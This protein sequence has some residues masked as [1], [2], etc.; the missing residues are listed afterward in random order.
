[1]DIGKRL[2]QERKRLGLSQT[3]FAKN[4]GVSISSQ[5]RYESGDR[6]PDTSYLK[7]AISLGVDVTYILTNKRHS[8]FQNEQTGVDEFYLIN[9]GIVL[10]K[11]FKLSKDDLLS[12]IHSIDS[13]MENDE[14]KNLSP[15]ESTAAFE[16]IFLITI[17]EILTAKALDSD[18]GKHLQ[19]I[20]H[21]LLGEILEKL[22]LVKKNNSFIPSPKKQALIVTSLYR[23]FKVSGKVDLELIEDLLTLS[24]ES[25]L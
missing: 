10:M 2:V 5:K 11:L 4:V 8:S 23:T 21:E 19:V 7:R 16:E 22:E 12:A 9:L 14:Y 24:T 25:S 1:M 3:T 6:E 17:S 20:D 15:N 18:F 13:T